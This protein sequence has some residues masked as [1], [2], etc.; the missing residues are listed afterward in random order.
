MEENKRSY[1][2]VVPANVRYDKEL[3]ANAKLLYGEITALCN[4]KGYCWAT[5]EYFAKLYNV[6]KQAISTWIRK[7]KENGYINVEIVYREGTKEILHRYIKIFE[8]PIKENFN[9]PIKENFNTPIKENF[10]DNNT[11]INNT[12]NNNTTNNAAADVVKYF[13]DNIGA[14]TPA[15]AEL[16]FS[17]L[18]D[19][20]NSELVIEA[21]KIA[22]LSNNR[23]TRYINGILKNWQSKNYKVVADIQ[24][25]RK[26]KNTIKGRNYSEEFLEN[27][28]S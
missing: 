28:Y 14:I 17:Y 4:E 16:L 18:D 8:H 13:E 22:T 15:A 10:K 11:Y 7:L 9:T 6:S 20:M 5:N 1:F 21:I 27:L 25:E 12:Y 26:P 3:S 24:K 19:G 2:A 23:N